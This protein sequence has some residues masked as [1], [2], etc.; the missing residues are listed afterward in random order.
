M[1][2]TSSTRVSCT[3]DL[4]PCVLLQVNSILIRNLAM[5]DLLMGIYLLLVA[6]VDQHY[7]GLYSVHEEVWRKSHLCQL[8]GFL[9]TLSSEITVFTLASRL[10]LRK[11]LSFPP[12]LVSFL[13]CILAL[14]LGSYTLM[15]YV[16][17]HIF[18]IFLIICHHFPPQLWRWKGSIPLQ[19]VGSA[20]V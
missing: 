1:I 13:S 11:G 14:T 17:V 18:S 2:L 8:A 10:Q 4:Y 15:I 5:G 7:R 16:N 20:N 9:S 3:S 6:S 12:C 19:S